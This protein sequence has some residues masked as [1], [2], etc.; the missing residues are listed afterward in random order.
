MVEQFCKSPSILLF[1]DAYHLSD[2][3]HSGGRFAAVHSGL[4]WR[5]TVVSHWHTFRRARR[6]TCMLAYPNIHQHD[7]DTRDMTIRI[8]PPQK[9][10]FASKLSRATYMARLTKRAE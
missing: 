8:T 5:C 1:A 9:I 4:T 6:N 7:T 3:H 10:D 2:P